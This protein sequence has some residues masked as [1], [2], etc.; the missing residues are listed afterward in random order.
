MILVVV[1]RLRRRLCTAN[2]LAYARS[3]HYGWRERYST[4]TVAWMSVVVVAPKHWYDVILAGLQLELN[5]PL[6]WNLL[7]D[8]V[9]SAALES[10]I[11]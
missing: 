9:L 10:V 5:L 11:I 4:V 1:Q 7:Y 8:P 3:Y 6:P 2:D